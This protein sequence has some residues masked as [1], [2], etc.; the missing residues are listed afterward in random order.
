[1]REPSADLGETP[2]FESL[3]PG[4]LAVL[5]ERVHLRAFKPQACLLECGQDS[6]G[7]YVIRSGLVA[8]FLRSDAGQERELARLERGECV[9]E[10]A[11]VTGEPCSAIV[12]AITD[13][14]SA[15]R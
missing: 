12:R 5:R 14:A 6:P 7:L 2:L 3:T 11:L 13:S 9:G 8:V 10:M 1:V 15:V 4:E